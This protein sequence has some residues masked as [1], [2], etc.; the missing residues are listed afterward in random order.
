MRVCQWPA[1]LTARASIES[2][3]TRTLRLVGIM[4]HVGTVPKCMKARRPLHSRS[5]TTG[6][7]P[8]EGGGQDTG[9][10]SL[11]HHW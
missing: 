9:P 8:L 1:G 11:S 3:S 10:D 7:A 6:L 2:W 5:A 4:V